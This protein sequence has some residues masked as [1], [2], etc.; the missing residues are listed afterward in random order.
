MSR[1]K[2]R[3]PSLP[4]VPKNRQDLE[5]LA[6]LGIAVYHHDSPGV[7]V[8]PSASPA[9]GEF[10]VMSVVCRCPECNERLVVTWRWKTRSGRL[11]V[12]ADAREPS[13]SADEDRVARTRLDVATAPKWIYARCRRHGWRR[14]A[15]D[16][17]LEAN[18]QHSL[19][20][21]H[22][23]SDAAVITVRMSRTP[24]RRGCARL[25]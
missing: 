6:A 18:R 17:L 5:V 9:P 4:V 13:D 16:E 15:A 1:R 11:V 7:P 12:V 19:E 24:P 21:H 2:A 22:R 23:G 8:V 3:E 14:A 25:T 10:R 20:D